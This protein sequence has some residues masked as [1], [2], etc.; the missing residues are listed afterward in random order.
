MTQDLPSKIW[1]TAAEIA[2]AR[3]PDLPT[4]KRKVNE[5]AAREGWANYPGKSQRRSGKGGGLEYHFSLFPVRAR[6]TLAQVKQEPEKVVE[7]R[8]AADAWGDYEQQT[9]ANKA[10]AKNRLRVV[11]LVNQ[12]SSAGMTKT[13]AVREAAKVEAISEKTLWNWLEMV[14]GVGVNDR[15]AYLAPRKGR[16]RRSSVVLDP[17]FVSLIRSDWLR[18]SRPSLTS[19][20]DRAVRVAHKEGLEIAPLAAIRTH[21]KKE[22]SKPTEIYLRYGA[23]ALRRHYPHQDRDKSALVPLEC[24]CG[25]YHRFDVFVRW[26]GEPNPVRVQMVVFSDVYSGKLLSWRLSL[27]ANS[28]T[29]QLCL[30]DVIR[31]FGIPQSAVLDNGR[32]FAS[33][34]ITGGT[35]TRFRFKVRD[36]DVPGLLPLFGIKV[37]WARPNSGQSKPIERAFRDLCDRV[38]KHP[39]FEGAYTGNKPDAK[40]ENYG[41]RA[42]PL[43]EFRRILDAEILEHNARVDRRSKVAKGRSFNEVFNA[44]YKTAPIRKASDEQLRM[45]LLTAEGIRCKR[46]NGEIK[47]HG[48]RY[49]SDWMC[50]VAGKRVVVRFDPDNLHE[51]VHVSDLEGR[52]LGF[53]SPISK[54]GFNNLQDAKDLARKRAQFIRKSK[55]VAR[56]EKTLQDHEIAAR[57]RAA[58][59]PVIAGDLPETSL[60]QLPAPHRNAPKFGKLTT[61]SR[62]P[63]GVTGLQKHSVTKVPVQREENAETRFERA[64]ALE[65]VLETGKALPEGQHAWLKDY[66]T[67]AEYGAHKK[68]REAFGWESGS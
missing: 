43:D 19:C 51:G 17:E 14:D 30:G 40:P 47:L 39:E 10:K 54:G 61:S 66:Q 28:H 38:A 34:S 1:W 36:N 60:L 25:D 64:L 21:L 11:T 45:W 6:V 2:D 27:T 31:N 56:A 35:E 15:L 48:N 22:V 32:E 4:T 65:E 5:R 42:V 13:K 24:V 12:F 41:S 62:E 37:I 33:K 3:L 44:G 18:N 16:G 63:G 7:K 58:S 67:S 55:E 52:Y 49:W 46:D 29:V 20:Y 50:R 8:T 23:E 59:E 9:V 57:L 53:A 68:M 26:P